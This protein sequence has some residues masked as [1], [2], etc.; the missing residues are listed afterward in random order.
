MT[1]TYTTNKNIEKPAYNDYVANP[2]G[3]SGPINTD[4]DIIDAAFGGVTVK[5]PTGV[6]GTVAL[7]TSEYQKLIL[8]FG[9][10]I[11]GQATLT[12]NITYTI[13]FGVGGQWIIYNN[14]TGAYSINFE[15]ASGGG[16]SVTVPQAARSLV[17]SDGTNC[18][19]VSATPLSN[20]ITTAMLQDSSVTTAKIADNSVTYAKIESNS[21]ASVA[22]FRAATASNLLN[23]NVPWDAAAFVTLTDGASI[24]L[25]MATGFNFQV[26]LGGNRA[27]AN[28]TN[29]K[30]GQSGVIV[31][32]QDGTGSRTMTFG[33]SYKFANGIAPT[34]STAGGAIDMLFYYVYA[35][36]FILINSIRGVA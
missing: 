9:T 27:L 25:D 17:Y 21:I 1:S 23:A 29:I 15:Q 32:A 24:A 34:L 26:T 6:S 11:S 22:E 5:N 28:P 3:W 31:V 18:A 36:N 13:P 33:S 8:V 4:W 7:T 14:T 35:S 20:S 12:A 2:T 30:I 10:S 16:T 19:I